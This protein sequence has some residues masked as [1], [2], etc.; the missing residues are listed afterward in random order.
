MSWQFPDI[1]PIA[2]SIGPFAVRWYALAYLI[3]ILAGWKY[4]CYL[5]KL[6]F[7]SREEDIPLKQQA[8]DDFLP[9]AIGGIILGGRFGYILFYQFGYYLH[10]PAEILAVWH[11]GMSFHGGAIG[12]I[13]AMIIYA[14]KSKLP[15][16]RLTDLVCCAVPIGLFF[17][18]LAN[19]INGE[20]YGRVTQSSIGM[21]FPRG[22]DLPRHPSQL[23]EA[24]LEGL[25]LFIVLC[26]L[27]HKNS[28]RDKPGILS[29]VFLIGYGLSRFTIEFF[30][31]P[32]EQIG[33]IA[34][35]FTMGQLLCV[36]MVVG[37]LACI[38]YALRSKNDDGV[39]ASAAK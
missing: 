21:V 26:I 10:H 16:L 2:V 24:T 37:G 33:Y 15:L 22:G 32:D 5:A 12:V 4:V 38:V 17:G 14:L 3:G 25:L 31:E 23:Y 9:W 8:L 36:P 1:D 34:T 7:E 27:A 19:F 18:R 11:G 13:I 39:S 6:G 35:Y 29:G 28:I 30:R 20:L